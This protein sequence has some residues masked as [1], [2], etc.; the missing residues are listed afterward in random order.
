VTPAGHPE[1]TETDP[2]IREDTRA[3]KGEEGHAKIKMI[4]IKRGRYN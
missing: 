3:A 1:G 4:K 2:E